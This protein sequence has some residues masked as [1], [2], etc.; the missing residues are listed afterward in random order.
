MRAKRGTVRRLDAPLAIFA[1][2][3]GMGAA[4]H[5]YPAGYDWPY[6]TISVLLYRDHNPHGYLW[7]WLGLWVCG[8][9]GLAWTMQASRGVESGSATS[10]APGLRLL[11]L[12]FLFMCCAVVPDQLLPWRRGHELFALLAFIGI[13]AGVAL[14]MTKIRRAASII[15]LLPLLLAGATQAYLTLRRPNLPWVTPAWRT[16]GISPLLSF[17]LWEWVTCG[18]FSAC[19]LVL[20]KRSLVVYSRLHA[21]PVAR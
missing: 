4:A 10:F 17:G 14:Q 8:L 20:W 18:V 1:F 21:P 2:W 13:S 7:A 3:C 9:A 5:A 15:P 16:L 6:Q 19:L 12:G 11:Q